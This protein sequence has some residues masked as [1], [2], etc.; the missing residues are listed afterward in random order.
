MRTRVLFLDMHARYPHCIMN[1]MWVFRGFFQTFSPLVQR[2]RDKRL[3]F[4]FKSVTFLCPARMH[5]RGPLFLPYDASKSAL[6]PAHILLSRCSHCSLSWAITLWAGIR[7]TPCL[8][9]TGLQETFPRGVRGTRVNTRDPNNDKITRCKWPSRFKRADRRGNW[10]RAVLWGI[11]AVC[12][13]SAYSG[14]CK[15]AHL[16]AAMC[17]YS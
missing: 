3:H 7:E 6:V 10:S 14:L 2:A 11:D 4:I 12:S 9:S 13:T 15:D 8:Q 5:T 1:F 17:V 16:C